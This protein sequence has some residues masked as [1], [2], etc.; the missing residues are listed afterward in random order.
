VNIG[1]ESEAVEVPIP[2]H[3]DDIPAEPAAPSG[4]GVPEAEPQHAEPAK[5]PA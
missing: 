1:E 4:P 5:V 3:P 2:V